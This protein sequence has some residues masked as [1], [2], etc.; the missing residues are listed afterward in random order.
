MAFITLGIVEVRCLTILI[1]ECIQQE[2][3]LLI[4][5]EKIITLTFSIETLLWLL[6]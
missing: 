3:W 6:Y 4:S 5:P 2:P 1:P